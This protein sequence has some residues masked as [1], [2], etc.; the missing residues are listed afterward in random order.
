[1]SLCPLLLRRAALETE[2]TWRLP[3][4]AKPGVQAQPIQQ[5]N[6]KLGSSQAGSMCVGELSITQLHHSHAWLCVPCCSMYAI[7]AEYGGAHVSPEMAVARCASPWP[8]AACLLLP[9]L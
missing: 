5:F 6:S 7:H 3:S 4:Q 2:V 1:M 9:S 8:G